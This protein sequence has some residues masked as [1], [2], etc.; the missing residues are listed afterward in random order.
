MANFKV[1]KSFFEN[2]DTHQIAKDLLGKVLVRNHN[3][4]KIQAGVIVETESYHGFDDLASHAAKSRTKRNE[5]MFGEGGHYYV[6]LIYGMYWNLNIVTG[7]KEFPSAILI[8]ALEPIYD[9]ELDLE[10]LNFGEKL[11]LSSGPGKLCRWMGIDKEFYGKSVE[12]NNLFLTELKNLSLIVRERGANRELQE[13][14]VLDSISFRSNNTIISTKRI[15]V[16]YAGDWAHKDWR[17]Y[18]KDNKFV[19]KI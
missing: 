9:S 15:G 10:K 8:R 17:F 12:N 3:N 5:V 16:D 13:S 19:S 7:N 6:Y 14:L 18:I 1:K 2:D 4:G 11:K